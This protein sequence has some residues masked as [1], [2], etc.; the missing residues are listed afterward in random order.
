MKRAIVYV[1]ITFAVAFA[2]LFLMIFIDRPYL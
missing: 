1:A 2:L